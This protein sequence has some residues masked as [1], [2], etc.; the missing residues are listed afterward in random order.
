[1][2]GDLLP[3]PATVMLVDL[4]SKKC[5]INELRLALNRIVPG[6]GEMSWVY[7]LTVLTCTIYGCAT[8][9]YDPYSEPNSLFHSGSPSSLLEKAVSSELVSEWQI[10]LVTG[11]NT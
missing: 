1:V 9:N 5:R 8:Q 6:G 7:T 2:L 4:L 11:T 10:S 3:K